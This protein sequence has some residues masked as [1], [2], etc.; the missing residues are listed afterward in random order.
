VKIKGLLSSRTVTGGGSIPSFHSSAG[1]S[2]PDLNKWRRSCPFLQDIPHY[3][4]HLLQK[5]TNEVPARIKIKT[6]LSGTVPYLKRK[7]FVHAEDGT[8]LLERKR[9]SP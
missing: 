7:P 8:V 5:K 9:T 1:K 2:S 3:R 4:H 6:I